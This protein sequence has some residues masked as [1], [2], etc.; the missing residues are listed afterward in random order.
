MKRSGFTL[1]ELLIVV[2][3][4]GILAGALMPM[5]RQNRV[6]AQQARVRADLDAIKTASLM[7]HGDCGAGDWP[8]AGV[9]GIGITAVSP[10]CAAPPAGNWRGPYLDQWS[11]DPWNN[12]YRII[13]VGVAPAAV[14]VTLWSYGAD[15]AVGGAVGSANE[16]I[17]L[18][19][20]PDRPNT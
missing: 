18:R 10:S 14:V 1:I 3:I 6:A 11:N 2:V 17:P 12:P 13:D 7:Y 4:I 9:A 16:D 5:F 15:N 8:P 20:T 19:L